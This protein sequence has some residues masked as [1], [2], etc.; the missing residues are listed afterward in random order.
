MQNRCRMLSWG[1]LGAIV[2]PRW[3]QG[4]KNIEVSS[5]TRPNGPIGN[6]NRRKINPESIQTVIAFVIGSWVGFG[7]TWPQLGP[8][9]AAKSL[10][11]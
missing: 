6:Q 10:P 5:R 2:V 4:A 3:V 1:G 8:K 9:L 7:G 11:K